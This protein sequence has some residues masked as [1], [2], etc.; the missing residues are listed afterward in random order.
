M[1]TLDGA[2]NGH[3]ALNFNDAP[4]DEWTALVERLETE[5]GFSRVGKAVLAADSTIYQGFASPDFTLAA[6]YDCW[7]GNYL[8]SD[9]ASGDEFLERLHDQLKARLTE[10]AETMPDSPKLIG[11]WQEDGAPWVHP[12][13][14]VDANWEVTS[15]DRIVQYLQSGAVVG[16]Y[17]GFSF[18]RFQCGISNHQ[19]GNAELTDG[20]WV[21]PQG[22]AHYVE[23]HCVRLPSEF[24][25]TMI[26]NNFKIPDKLDVERLIELPRS[27]NAWRLFCGIPLSLEI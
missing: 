14:F 25:G 12:S 17:L 2:A 1:I 4:K 3:L 24:V 23:A 18:C 19:M 20:E 5:F 16:E 9:S 13:A 22:L 10:E 11:Y 8:L 6:G 27:T 21:W 26:A 15:R 7:S